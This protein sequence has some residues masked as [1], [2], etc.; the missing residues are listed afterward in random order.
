MI[1]SYIDKSI[2]DELENRRKAL[3][4]ESNSPLELGT[5]GTK[6]FNKYL[7]LSLAS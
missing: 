5:G 7:S 6:Q 4:R 3:A 1:V 2:Q